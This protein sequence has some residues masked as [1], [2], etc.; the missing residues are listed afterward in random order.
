MPLPAVDKALKMDIIWCLKNAFATHQ[1][2]ST[3][4][5]LFSSPADKGGSLKTEKSAYQI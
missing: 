2:V 4:V 3:D 5:L 1:E